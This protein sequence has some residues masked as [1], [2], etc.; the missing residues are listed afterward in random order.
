MPSDAKTLNVEDGNAIFYCMKE[1]LATFKQIC[2]KIYDVSIVG[3]SDL[4]F[5][6]DM[7]KENSIKSLERT[8]RGSGQKRIIKGEGTKRPENWKSFL[9]N[10]F[11]KQQ[12][13][14]FLLKVWSN[15][16]FGRKLQN[17]TVIFTCEEKAYLL[18]DNRASVMMTEIPK[19]ESDQEET[20]TRVVLY[21][22]YAADEEYNYVRVRSPDSDIFFI[23]FYYA[24][25]INIT[26]LFDT[27]SRCKRRLLDISQFAHD[28]TP[29]YCS[30][31]LGLHA[32]SRC[33]T[34]NAFKGIGKV[35][36]I[37]LPQKK[38]RY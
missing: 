33:D 2:E 1:M 13:V 19:L 26:L 9:S 27:G 17:K 18:K 8:S 7:Y 36:P 34:T 30:A 21:C 22:F 16:D 23:L 14:R 15:D 4:L 28:F 32:F 11:N 20:D 12:L 6:T 3:K 35:K 29:F 25:K 24:S 38:P 37:K 31:L 10:N 5:S